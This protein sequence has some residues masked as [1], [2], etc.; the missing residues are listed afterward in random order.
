M[1][2]AAGCVL[3]SSAVAQDPV[4]V[5]P[6]KAPTAVPMQKHLRQHVALQPNELK[7]GAGPAALPAGAKAASLCGDP[8]QPGPFA[9]RLRL[10]DGYKIPPHWHPA[11][12]NVTVISGTFHLGEGD[13]FDKSKGKEFPS[14]GF[15]AMPAGM[16]HFAW[17]SGETE[18]QLH[19][20]GPWDIKYVNPSDDP[21]ATITPTGRSDK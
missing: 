16:H 5:D 6:D 17:V 13:T 20:I 12:E 19:G 10:P 11:D 3:V 14:G 2:V 7:W 15:T 8:Q 4:T 1:L 18:I 21:R 9:L